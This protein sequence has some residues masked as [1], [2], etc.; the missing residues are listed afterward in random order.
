MFIQAI[1]YAVQ[2]Q[3]N[4]IWLE[5]NSTYIVHLLLTRSTKIPWSLKAQWS[6]C[7]LKFQLS[8]SVFLTFFVK[9][10]RLQIISQNL[11][12]V[13]I[14]LPGALLF[15]IFV[16]SRM[17]MISWERVLLDFLDVM[18]CTLFSFFGFSPKGF[19]IEKS[20]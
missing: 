18:A 17:L 5:S 8:T 9:E 19:F 11:L 20:S 14:Q 2:Y 13:L 12:L 10:T 16:T 7:L 4:N 6:R 1:D 15:L 3:W